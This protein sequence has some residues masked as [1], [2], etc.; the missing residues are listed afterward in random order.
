MYRMYRAQNSEYNR[1]KIELYVNKV[2]TES[3]NEGVTRT[4]HKQRGKLAHTSAWHIRQQNIQCKFAHV[5]F[6]HTSHAANWDANEKRE[7]DEINHFHIWMRY[8]RQSERCEWPKLKFSVCAWLKF[9]IVH[10]RKCGIRGSR[11]RNLRFGHSTHFDSLP[12]MFFEP[13]NE[14]VLRVLLSMNFLEWIS[15]HTHKIYE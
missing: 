1:I 7:R 5:Q 3:Q 6:I 4:G 14:L 2:E 8:A 9:F 15:T 13:L 11:I 10:I 12:S